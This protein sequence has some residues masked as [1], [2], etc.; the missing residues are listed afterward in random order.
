MAELVFDFSD[1]V[2]QNIDSSNSEFAAMKG[3]KWTEARI[4]AKDIRMETKC[5]NEIKKATM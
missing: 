4:T 5:R 2:Q 1:A 3:K